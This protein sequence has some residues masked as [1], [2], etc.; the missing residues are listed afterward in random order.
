MSSSILILTVAIMC[1]TTVM[2][3]SG[4]GYVS[5]GYGGSHD[6]FSRT[7]VTHQNSHI[8]HHAQVAQ[9]VAHVPVVHHHPI[10]SHGYEHY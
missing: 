1:V 10:V 6:A 2:A 4:P 3:Q 9:P 8:V 7:S 5:G